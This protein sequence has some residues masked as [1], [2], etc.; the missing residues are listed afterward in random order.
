MFKRISIGMVVVFCLTLVAAVFPKEQIKNREAARQFNLAVRAKDPYQKISHYLKAIELE[1]KFVEALYNLGLTYKKLKDW[2]N[3]EKYFMQ[4]YTAKP[5]ATPEALKLKLL[6][7]L[8]FATQKQGKWAEAEEALRGA[9]ALAKDDLSRAQI[10]LHL[11][12][13]LYEQGRYQDA[14]IELNKGRDLPSDFQPQFQQLIAQSEDMLNMERLYNEAESAKAAGDLRR[15]RSLYQQIYAHNKDF[16]N[17]AQRLSELDSILTVET[18][19]KNLQTSLAQADE[20]LKQGKIELA[21]ALLEELA[22]KN[23]E[24]DLQKKLQSAREA[25]RRKQ[26]EDQLQ[27][28]Y[29]SGV[30]AMRFRNWAAAVYFFEKI[31]NAD[32]NFRDARRR[33]QRAQRELENQNLDNALKQYYA[34]GV[35]ALKEG[36]YQKAANALGKV[37]NINP[38]YLDVQQLLARVEAAQKQSATEANGQ[39]FGTSDTQLDSLYQEALALMDENSWEEALVVLE[40]IRLIDPGYRDA[41]DLLATARARLATSAAPGAAK[42]GTSKASS[43]LLWSVLFFSLV[44]LPAVGAYIFLPGVRARYYLMRGNYL[45]AAQVYER[46]L[47]RNP[48]KIQVYKALADLYLLTGRRDEQAMKV[49]KMVMRLNLDTPKQE[50]INALLTQNYLK[51]GK[52]DEDAISVLEAALKAETE[53]LQGGNL[54]QKTD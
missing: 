42:K 12:R 6:Y 40:K 10:L 22:A 38:D 28:D 30:N 45:A 1:P 23:P 54:E 46:M 34:N 39:N 15:A 50:E 14:L 24:P 25:L 9:E 52:T 11:G 29:T 17:V 48:G 51:E 35:Q 19:K 47:E 4:A 41:L 7:E 44:A 32:P 49:F 16:R 33:L 3:A 43:P 37:A 20:Y 27:R 53:R 31:V 36:D 26:L 13:I 21:V 8:S 18:S 5:N 2:A